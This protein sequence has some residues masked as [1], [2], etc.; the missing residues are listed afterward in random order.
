VFVYLGVKTETMNQ[1]L[2]SFRKSTDSP[3]SELLVQESFTL[4]MLLENC[5]QLITMQVEVAAITC[6][7]QL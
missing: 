3:N 7:R 4:N 1:Q 6:C 5:L 2:L